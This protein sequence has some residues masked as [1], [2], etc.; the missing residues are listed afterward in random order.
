VLRKISGG[1]I[2]LVVLKAFMIDMSHLEGVLR[3]IS[4]IGLGGTLMGIGFVYQRALRGMFAQ[5]DDAVSD[6][7]GSQD[8]QSDDPD[9]G[10]PS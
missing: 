7:D 8:I 3:A 1:I 5:T 10:K 9:N 6:M 4:F 2:L